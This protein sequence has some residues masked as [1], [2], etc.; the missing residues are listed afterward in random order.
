M[1]KE[2]KLPDKTTLTIP[3]EVTRKARGRAISEGTSM[4]AVVT[5]LLR[6]WLDGQIVL[7]PEGELAPIREKGGQRK[8]K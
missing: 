8:T 6:F 7:T 4:S 5:A 1:P 2:K 3:A